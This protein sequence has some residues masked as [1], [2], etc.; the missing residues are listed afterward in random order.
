MHYTFAAGE[1]VSYR[2]PEP[3]LFANHL[4]AFD[5][6]DDRL[7]INPVERFSDEDEA[8]CAIEPF[9][10]A[11]EIAAD[12]DSSV[13][14][15]QFEFDRADIV[16]HDPPPLGASRVIKLKAGSFVMT[17]GSVSFH[18]TRRKYPQPPTTFHATLEVQHAYRR[19]LGFRAG[20]EPLQAMAY[21]VL[22]LLESAVGGRPAAARLFQIDGAVLGTIGKLS[23]T[24]GDESTARKAAAGGQFQELSGAERQWLEEAIRRLIFRLGEHAS[25]VPLSVIS[26]TDL[27]N[28]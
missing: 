10:R 2:D 24:K 5:L 6:V 9:L 1:G 3:I 19:W 22:T 13:G 27:P 28:L 15:I 11:W 4:G 23:S 20:K 12:L 25:G 7:R 17:G 18:V 14:Q 16:D 21:F 8:R 26:M